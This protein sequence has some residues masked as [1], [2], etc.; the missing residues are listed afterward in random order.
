M[1][2]V[3]LPSRL[4]GLGSVVSS[5]SWFRGR[6]PAGNAF[7]RILEAKELFFWTYMLKYLEEGEDRGLGAIVPC[8]NVEPRLR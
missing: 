8:L 7:W 5:P 4:W 6:P 2:L 1:L 3:C